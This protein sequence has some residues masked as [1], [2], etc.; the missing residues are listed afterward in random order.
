[1]RWEERTKRMMEVYCG[2]VKDPL[3]IVSLKLDLFYP[4]AKLPE[5]VEKIVSENGNAS[6]SCLKYLSRSELIEIEK[7]CT[8]N[9]VLSRAALN[10]FYMAGRVDFEVRKLLSEKASILQRLSVWTRYRLVQAIADNIWQNIFDALL[11][12]PKIRKL[13][14]ILL[15]LQQELK[16]E[17]QN[18]A[19]LKVIGININH[20]I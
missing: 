6:S 2:N 14:N 19:H 5:A 20:L 11:D 15:Q 16:L 3:E 8:E 4:L 13:R 10:P 1:M 7:T 18:C 12:D 9:L 17:N